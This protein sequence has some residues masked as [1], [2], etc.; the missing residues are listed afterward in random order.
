LFG[1]VKIFLTD[2]IRDYFIINFKFLKE[3]L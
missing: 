1:S 3:E 2:I